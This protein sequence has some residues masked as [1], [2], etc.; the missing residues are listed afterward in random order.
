MPIRAENMALYPKDWKLIRFEI[1]ERADHCCEGTPDNPNC[2][3]PNKSIHPITNSKVVLTIAHMDR[4]LTDHSPENLRALCQRCHN[5]WDAK[6]R[7]AGIKR[8]RNER[9]G[10][11]ELL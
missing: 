4:Q 10:Q 3:V 9:L 1:L 2:R 8:R 6:D 5:Q 7:A 11:G